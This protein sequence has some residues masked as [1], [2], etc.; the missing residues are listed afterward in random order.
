MKVLILS[1][2]TGQGHNTAGRALLDAFQRR[3]VPCEMKDALS[4]AGSHTSEIVSQL[5]TR[6]TNSAPWFFGGLYRVG[7]ALSAHTGRVKSP[8]YLINTGYA[9]HLMQYIEEGGFDAV[10]SLHLFAMEALTYLRHKRGLKARLYGV[11]TDY[12][13]VPF[14]DEADI[15]YSF[16]PHA[17]LTGEYISQGVPARTLVPSG[18]P[19]SL[20]FSD[21]MDRAA[22]RRSLNISTDDRL[23]LVMTGSMG[24]GNI[25]SILRS[26]SAYR[27]PH[28]HTLVLTG[29]NQ[30]LFDEVTAMGEAGIEPIAYTDQ[31]PLYMQ[32]CDVLVTK[33]GG[34]TSTEAAVR[35]VPLVHTDPIPG[36]ETHNVT[37][38]QS[39]GM[40][41]CYRSG[42]DPYCIAQLL[43]D[44]A[45]QEAMRAAQRRNTNPHAADDICDFMLKHASE[46]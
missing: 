39:H 6:I 34:L 14:W 20:R 16:I 7:T 35:N 23:L 11:A 13:C 42:E 22:A 17:D 28:R 30:E 33:P 12:T 37:F 1:C 19:V 36:W 27:D 24:F 46:A 8:I 45:A 44:E 15:D 32:A 21:E 25:S 29:R 5:Y 2:P 18:I 43:E 10:I 9:D 41:T 31:V 38:F 4:F 26:L 3:N 40:S